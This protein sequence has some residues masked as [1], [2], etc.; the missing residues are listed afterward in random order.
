M[1]AWSRYGTLGVMG[2]DMV[3]GTRWIL[4]ECEE[5]KPGEGWTH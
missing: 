4:V 2:E 3:V 1:V 5:G